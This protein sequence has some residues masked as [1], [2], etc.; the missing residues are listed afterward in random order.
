MKKV[1]NI[2]HR[3]MQIKSTKRYNYIPTRVATIKKTDTPNIGNDVKQSKLSHTASEN[4]KWSTIL[5]N[6]WSISYNQFSINIYLFT[7]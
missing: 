6:G 1:F 7:D 5:A 3:Q 2:T 4:V